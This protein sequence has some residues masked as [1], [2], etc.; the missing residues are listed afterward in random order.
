MS[1]AQALYNIHVRNWRLDMLFSVPLLTLQNNVDLRC[2][3]LFHVNFNV[4]SRV[5]DYRQGLD[6]WLDLLTTWRS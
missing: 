6:W 5:S 3:H 1:I 4:L 2:G